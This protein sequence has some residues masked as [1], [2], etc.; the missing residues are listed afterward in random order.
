M[1]DSS[2]IALRYR[3]FAEL[4]CQGYSE[5]YYRLA[6]AVAEDDDVVGFLAG[7]PVIQPNLFFA[8]IQFLTGPHRMP[9]TGPQLKAFL[10]QDSMRWA[11]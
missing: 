5:A 8:S 9:S 1:K 3:R 7:M 10:S 11:T 6:L 4:E 2:D